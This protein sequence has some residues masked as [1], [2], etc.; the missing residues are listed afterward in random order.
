MT[1]LG[2]LD[3][4]SPNVTISSGTTTPC[5]LP[6]KARSTSDTKL[7]HILS[8]FGALNAGSPFSLASN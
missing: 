1:V 5:P 4:P 6:S 8:Y 2:I 3:G 7:R